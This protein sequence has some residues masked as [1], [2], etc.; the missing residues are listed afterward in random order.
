MFEASVEDSKFV[1]HVQPVEG[2]G[3]KQ[4][5]TVTLTRITAVTEPTDGV[6][7]EGVKIS[8]DD[9][10][11]STTSITV[12]EYGR[13]IPYTSLAADLSFWDLEN[14]IQRGLRT[15][16][17]RTMDTAAAAGFKAAKIKYVPTGEATNNIATNGTAATQAL[18]NLNMWHIEQIH[19]YLFDT[20][21]AEP[22]SGDTYLAIC[23]TLALRGIMQ[24]PEW[25]EWKKYTDPSAK[26]NGEVGQIEDIRFIKTNHNKAL[27][28]K[29]SSSV[30][31]E[32][33]F[34]GADAVA[35]AE[36]LT[37][38]LRAAMPGDYGRAQAVAWYGI[39]AFGIIWDT[40]NAGQA[41]IVHVTST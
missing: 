5:E 18:A 20:L 17:T 9:Y 15:Q 35:M 16:M 40:G 37:P 11:L 4:G 28:K 23:R 14:G 7:T 29:G 8:E 25:A 26:F 33:V 1:D 19:D 3:R 41:K 12:K 31:G 22:F 27:G 6:L 30:L 34:F 38:E 21:L 32:A 39:L 13:A 24:D 10:A 2:F 36:V